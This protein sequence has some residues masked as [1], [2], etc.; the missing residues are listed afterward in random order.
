[1][2]APPKN[3]LASVS[4]FAA[5]ACTAKNVPDH[6]GA[7]VGFGL[8]AIKWNRA[9][10]DTFSSL[11]A[12]AP[13][14]VK[15]R[16]AEPA[17]QDRPAIH[18]ACTPPVLHMEPTWFGGFPGQGKTARHSQFEPPSGEKIRSGMDGSRRNPAMIRASG[19]PGRHP[20]LA[21]PMLS[22]SGAP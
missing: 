10:P 2:M 11:S 1:M 4:R 15:H 12:P 17:V 3:P 14:R 22:N 20:L 19:K 9:E 8:V 21:A 18:S 16:D 7:R 13:R 6:H 5:S